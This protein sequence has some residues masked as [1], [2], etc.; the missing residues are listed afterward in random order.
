MYSLEDEHVARLFQPDP[1]SVYGPTT[2]STALSNSRT[3]YAVAE[4]YANRV[5]IWDI[6]SSA[7]VEDDFWAEPN[8]TVFEGYGEVDVQAIAW[9]HD[10]AVVA[11]LSEDF[12]LRFWDPNTGQQYAETTLPP[13][14]STNQIVWSADGSE[15]L[16]VTMDAELESVPVS[17]LSVP[18]PSTPTPAGQ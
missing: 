10:D 14:A 3:R 18:P 9:R 17:G 4:R 1:V 12:K 2:T 11:S 6:E 16:Y 13:D 7:G 5:Y 8:S 15:I